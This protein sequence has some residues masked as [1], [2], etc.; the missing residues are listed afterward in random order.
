MGRPCDCQCVPCPDYEQISKPVPAAPAELSDGHDRTIIHELAGE[1][2]LTQQQILAGSVSGTISVTSDT[3]GAAAA[4]SRRLTMDLT[5]TAAP[6]VAGMIFWDDSGYQFDPSVSGSLAEIKASLAMRWVSRRNVIVQTAARPILI[7]GTAIEQGGNQYLSFYS[8][9]AMPPADHCWREIGG[10]AEDGT[11]PQYVGRLATH[12]EGWHTGAG[13]VPVRAGGNQL[14]G[15]CDDWMATLDNVTGEFDIDDRPD[16]SLNRTSVPVTRFGLWIG[17][18]SG[19]ADDEGLTNQAANGSYLFDA[20]LDDFVCWQS[21]WGVPKVFAADVGSAPN[22]GTLFDDEDLTTVPGTWTPT[23]TVI[24]DSAG[25]AEG[26]SSGGIGTIINGQLGNEVTWNGEYTN[27]RLSRQFPLP[28]LTESSLFTIEFNW[29]TIR[30]RDHVRFSG[31]PADPLESREIDAGVWFDDGFRW[32]ASKEGA[33]HPH[34]CGNMHWRADAHCLS[35][36]G[37]NAGGRTFSSVYGGDDYIYPVVSVMSGRINGDNCANEAQFGRASPMDGDRVM[38]LIRRV[39][40]DAEAAAINSQIY[41]N[42]SNGVYDQPPIGIA[43][44]EAR[45]IVHSYINGR[46]LLLG[47]NGELGTATSLPFLWF[48]SGFFTVGLFGMAGGRWSDL[49]IRVRS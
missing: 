26:Y 23:G 5:A 30:E 49:R 32:R 35:D 25:N 27:W 31:D 38:L 33:D 15:R 36:G 7:V 40:T 41:T 24:R 46:L 42:I 2:S 44:P 39:Y 28:T 43:Y 12:A 29:H 14:L 37:G 18:M 6:W 20:L 17:L 21:C 3:R 22:F 11:S 19:E 1:G 47:L 16:L 4:G 10:G 13:A 48:P 34:G 45:W 9:A 8:S